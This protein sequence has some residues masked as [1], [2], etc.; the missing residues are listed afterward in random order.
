MAKTFIKEWRKY[1]GLTQEQLA[2]M[3]DMSNSNLSR[4]E[5]GAVRYTSDSLEMIAHALAVD[6]TDLL[7]R[8]PSDGLNPGDTTP[9]LTLDRKNAQKSTQTGPTIP[10][11]SKMSKDVPVYGTA[12]GGPVG[13]FQMENGVIDYVRRPPGIA[14]AKDV[15]ALYIV[16]DSMEPRYQEGELV[17]VSSKRPVRPGDY[18]I[19]EFVNGDDEQVAYCKQLMRR[20]ASTLQL[21]QTNPERILELEMDRVLRIHRILT[22]NELMGV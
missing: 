9:S 15:Y 16:G 14:D 19:V 22:M 12:Q 4:I 7:S 8:G 13:A 2:D 18:V 1:R 6:V 10:A 3:I 17:Y 11:P 5:S 20:S 21:A